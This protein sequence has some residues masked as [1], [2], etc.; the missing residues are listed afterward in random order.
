VTFKER[1]ELAANKLKTNPPK[2]LMTRPSTSVTSSGNHTLE[3]VS[4]S[5]DDI[6]QI[7]N[8]DGNHPPLVLKALEALRSPNAEPSTLFGFLERFSARSHVKTY[9]SRSDEIQAM[10]NYMAQEQSIYRNRVQTALLPETLKMEHQ[11][12]ATAHK[13]QMLALGQAAAVSALTIAITRKAAECNLSLEAYLLR[14]ANDEEL[15]KKKEE[16][17]HEIEKHR[18]MTEIDRL[19][20]LERA[21]DQIETLTAASLTVRQAEKQLRSELRDALTREDEILG[22]SK[23]SEKL[24]KNLLSEVRSE[25]SSLKRRINDLTQAAGKPNTEETY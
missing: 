24:K 3:E 20:E 12:V 11:A 17:E 21:K 22:D 4:V 1:A 23:V 5:I 10:L 9:T 14:L 19:D 16:I 2:D 6:L 13:S 15:R 18:R 7:A 25:I 8:V